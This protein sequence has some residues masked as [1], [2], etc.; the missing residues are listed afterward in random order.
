MRRIADGIAVGRRQVAVERFEIG[1]SFLWANVRIRFR[2][3]E[4][5]FQLEDPDTVWRAVCRD[6]Q[7]TV[8]A[9]WRPEPFYFFVFTSRISMEK[10]IEAL[11]RFVEQSQYPTPPSTLADVA[12]T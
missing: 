8:S 2:M 1:D 11:L 7:Y 3:L 12:H 6:K 10:N 9:D 4:Q 5:P